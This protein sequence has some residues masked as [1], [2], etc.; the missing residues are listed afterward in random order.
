[1]REG[2][3]GARLDRWAGAL[4][5]LLEAARERADGKPW[6]GWLLFAGLAVSLLS[7]VGF[8]VLGLVIVWRVAGHGAGELAHGMSLALIWLLALLAV[9]PLSILRVWW[10]FSRDSVPRRAP[11]DLEAAERGDHAAAHRLGQGYLGRDPLSARAWFLRA[12][13]AGSPEAMVELAT[14]LR[15]GRGGPRDLPAARIWL[16][17]A[18]N[19][20]EPRARALLAEVE[21]RLGDRFGADA[22]V[23]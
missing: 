15:E 2:R 21:A 14:L 16:A 3:P 23:D 20:G 13:Q 4:Q 11:R 9:V 17:R 7:G 18:T 22:G 1:M 12:A 6:V 19:A 10:I 5:G 8:V